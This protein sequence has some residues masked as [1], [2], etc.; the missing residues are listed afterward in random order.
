L[1]HKAL[2]R[3]RIALPSNGGN[4]YTTD[5]FSV[6]LPE[7]YRMSPSRLW[8]VVAL[9]CVIRGGVDI[10]VASAQL[11]QAMPAT[12]ALPQGPSAP[13]AEQT[14]YPFS[15]PS[16]TSPS[17][18][19]TAVGPAAISPWPVAP[20]DSVPWGG[21]QAPGAAHPGFMASDLGTP[22]SGN[23]DADAAASSAPL[24]TND[25]VERVLTGDEQWTWQI[26]PSGLLY[27]TDLAGVH[28]P[29][30]GARFENVRGLGAIWDCT[31]G[32]RLGIIR[33]G[34]EDNFWPQGWQ[35][36]IE[37]AA[38]PRLDGSRN[39]LSNDYT[40]GVPLTT[41]SGPWEWKF[42][43]RHYCSHI[44]DLFLLAHPDFDRID[45][46]RDS[47]VSGLAFYPNPSLRLY[48]E[49]DWA[50]H[51][52]GP[53]EPWEFQFGLD[54][55]PPGPT[56]AWGAPFFAAAGHLRQVSD[57]GGSLTMETGWQWRGR[58]GHLVRVGAHYFNG[59]SEQAQFFKVWEQQVG[60]G[61]WYDF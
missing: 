23:N 48:G 26:V 20:S 33:Y 6:L 36:D 8:V 27:K 31:L 1:A 30:M 15:Y 3:A 59:M 51:T 7:G 22:R 4:R 49:A 14:A 60:G 57:F 44:G 35:L 39:L 9:T 28:E 29:R 37:G 13:Y 43:Y 50:F 17:P 42:G 19:A 45:Y 61:L 58:T 53:P 41:R 11:Q 5:P 40:F 21:N 32:A 52:L 2:R 25:Y 12:S 34:T 54:F 56:T 38:F 47:L 16:S 18:S 10:S 46:T 24:N 55:S